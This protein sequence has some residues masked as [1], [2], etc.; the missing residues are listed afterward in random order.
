MNGS[1]N[2][3]TMMGYRSIAAF[4]GIGLRTA[5]RWVAEG[6]LPPP[7]LRLRGI[8]RWRPET[9]QTWLCRQGRNAGKKRSA[10]ADDVAPA[11][12]SGDSI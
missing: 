6:V 4:L 11:E 7:D 5:K 8:V 9:V 12:K 10:K 2:M 1:D 3:S